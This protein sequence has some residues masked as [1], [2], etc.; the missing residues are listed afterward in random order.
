MAKCLIIKKKFMNGNKI[1]KSN[2]KTK[3]KFKINIK[4]KKIFDI[5]KNKFIRIKLSTKAI[6][7]INKKPINKLIKK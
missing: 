1:S 5:I 7:C 6:K 3:K 4:R 2:I